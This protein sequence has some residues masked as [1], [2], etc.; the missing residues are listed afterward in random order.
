MSGCKSFPFGTT[1]ALFTLSINLFSLFSLA[2][3]II[4]HAYMYPERSRI[5]FPATYKRNPTCRSINIIKA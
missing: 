1:T 2:I 3:L 4:S 5:R